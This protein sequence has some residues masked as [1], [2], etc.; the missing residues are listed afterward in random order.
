M[1]SNFIVLKATRYVLNVKTY[2]DF[3]GRT[4]RINSHNDATLTADIHKRKH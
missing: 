2:S 1:W 4:N 3:I